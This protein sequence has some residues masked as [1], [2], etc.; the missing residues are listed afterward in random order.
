MGVSYVE[1]RICEFI[2]LTQGDRIMAEY[3]AEFLRLSR[4]A[5][6]SV[7]TNYNKSIFFEE[8]L[9]YDLIVLIALQRERIFIW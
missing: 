7:V 9:S 6:Q 5:R 1:V 4:Y 3:E 8:G 2:G